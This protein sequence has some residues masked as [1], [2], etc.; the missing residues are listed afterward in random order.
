M[1]KRIGSLLITLLLM[2]LIGVPAFA[3][4]YVDYDYD[5]FKPEMKAYSIGDYLS[6]ETIETFNE[7]SNRI[8]QEYGFNVV[9][10]IT[11]DLEG[12]VEEFS[13][14][15]F[16]KAPIGKE[17]NENFVL[18]SVDM[19]GRRVDLYTYGNGMKAIVDSKV[20]Y[21]LDEI[22]VPALKSENYEGLAFNYINE[23]ENAIISWE[24]SKRVNS[25]STTVNNSVSTNTVST[26]STYK[27]INNSSSKST[28]SKVD[29]M[30][31]ILVGISVGAVFT[32]SL[33]IYKGLKHRPVK[34]AACA[35]H[36]TTDGSFR[37]RQKED[38]FL[39]SHTSRT[40]IPKKDENKSSGGG[41]SSSSHSHSSGNSHGGGSRGF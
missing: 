9:F 16:L 25:N 1:F 8:E 21:I 14:Y 28:K 29:A 24:D 17:Y 4:S 5:I 20:N 40:K 6:T 18:L 13:D 22:V 11:N 37:M 23:V 35:D 34:A 15:L 10:V 32:I 33:L 31:F 7:M 30:H 19:V 36:Y 26:T 12:S 2:I 39:R 3:T 41:G 27:P 38:V